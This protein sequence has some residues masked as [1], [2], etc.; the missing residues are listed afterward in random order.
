V[1]NM[2]FARTLVELQ[3]GRPCAREG[4]PPGQYIVIMRQKMISPKSMVAE[5]D[6]ANRVYRATGEFEFYFPSKVPLPV[7]THFALRRSGS[8]EVGWKPTAEDCL[9]EDWRKV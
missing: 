2:D 6:E 8:V 3:D 9:S 1:K 7:Q 5:T 4:W